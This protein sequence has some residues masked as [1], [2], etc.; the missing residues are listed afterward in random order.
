[1]ATSRSDDTP[2]DG[3]DDGVDYDTDSVSVTSTMASTWSE[4]ALYDVE[5]II[6]ERTY[7]DRENKAITQYLTKWV[8]YP[9][10]K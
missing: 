5:E 10:H 7:L 3:Y 8:G 4:T 2:D 6:S 1:M 9:L